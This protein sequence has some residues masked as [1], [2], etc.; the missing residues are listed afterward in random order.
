MFECPDCYLTFEEE[1][2]YQLHLE[3]VSLSKIKTH[4]INVANQPCNLYSTNKRH[5]FVK[6]HH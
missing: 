3:K 1:P 4:I 2:L 6:L 5:S